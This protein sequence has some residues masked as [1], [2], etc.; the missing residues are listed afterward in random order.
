MWVGKG[1][2]RQMDGE[3]VRGKG[4]GGE[5]G[6]NNDGL[7]VLFFL[8]SALFFFRFPPGGRI[9]VFYWVLLETIF[10]HFGFFS[11]FPGAGGGDD[12]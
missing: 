7:G 10:F 3:W 6:G 8:L 11:H 5:R 1:M 2:D 12:G 9:Q 4:R